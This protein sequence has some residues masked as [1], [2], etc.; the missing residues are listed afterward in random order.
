M[1]NN[2]AAAKRGL[3]GMLSSVVAIYFLISLLVLMADARR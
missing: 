2:V 3:D 1:M